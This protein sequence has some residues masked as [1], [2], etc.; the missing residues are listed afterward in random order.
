MKAFRLAGLLAAA[1]AVAGAIAAPASAQGSLTGYYFVIPGNHVDVGHG[2]DGG[3]VS[4]LVE[5]L[6]GPN[7]LPVA[8]TFAKNRTTGSGNIEDI[9]STTG[10][11]QWWS[12]GGANGNGIVA[13]AV[14]VKTDAVPINQPSNFFPTGDTK[15][16]PFR[17]VHWQGSFVAPANGLAS[18]ALSADD[19]AWLFVNGSLLIDNGGV[20]GINQSPSLV[21]A[22]DLVSGNTYNID[23]FFADRYTVQSGIVFKSNVQLFPIPEPMFFQMGSLVSLGG[24]GLFR[25]KKRNPFSA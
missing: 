14:P 18:F 5:K 4:G 19:D 22:T 2:I 9:N 13:D 7:G 11:L 23:L 17:S 25:M 1:L 21:G 12:V 10:E 8:T 15:N 3:V 24:L 6:L 16:P 20:K